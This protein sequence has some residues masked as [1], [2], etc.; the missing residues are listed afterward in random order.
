MKHYSIPYGVCEI[1]N[2]GELKRITEKPEYD[3]LVNSGMY[4]L[5]PDIL[6]SIPE[7]KFYNIPE[8]IN[9]YIVK[10]EKVGVYPISEKSWIDMGEFEQLQ[11]MLKRFD[12]K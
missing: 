4:I 5:E 12:I 7:D 1:K 9:D 6:S 3:F 2:G 8:L 10:K 11:H